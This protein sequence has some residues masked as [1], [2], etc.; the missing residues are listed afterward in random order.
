MKATM[1]QHIK[2][3]EPHHVEQPLLDQLAGLGWEVID[4]TDMKQTRPP[5]IGR[6]SPRS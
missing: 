4:L 6:A 1:P 3:D 2:L 5:P